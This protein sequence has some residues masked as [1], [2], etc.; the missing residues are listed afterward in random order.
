MSDLPTRVLLIVDVQYDFL[1]GGALAVSEGDQ[2][3][4]VINRL[5]PKFEIVIATQ[6]YHPAN[7]GSFAANHPNHK[8]G[9][10]IDLN[11]VAQVLWPTHCVQGTFGTLISDQLPLARLTR[12]IQK[13]TDPGIDSYSAFFDN[14]RKRATGLGDYLQKQKM[15]EVFACGLATDYCVK[16][17]ALD[18]V[19]LGLKTYLIGDACRGVDLQVGDSARALQEM[20]A[21][22]VIVTNS[23]EIL[24]GSLAN[25]G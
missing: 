14:A 21:A 10:F 11:G 23:T 6:D 17:S 5:I 20:Q 25:K 12:V 13:G 22:S 19:S 7:H 4:P 16:Y 9:D 1:S 2:V 18:S 3:I 8:I 15:V 24:S